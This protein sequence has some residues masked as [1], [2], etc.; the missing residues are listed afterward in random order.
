[1][2][3]T[4]EIPPGQRRDVAGAAERLKDPDVKRE[5][6]LFERR[7]CRI[8]V[9]RLERRQRAGRILEVLEPQVRRRVARLERV[10]A[11]QL[12]GRPLVRGRSGVGA[13]ERRSA[14]AVTRRH[15]PVVAPRSAACRVIA[16]A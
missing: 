15:A 7:P 9:R 14:S 11:A 16:S 4:R 3:V 12:A 2:R 8:G 1:M 10:R 13:A 6:A 5:A